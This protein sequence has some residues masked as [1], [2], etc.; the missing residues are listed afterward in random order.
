VAEAA[1]AQG[2][3]FAIAAKRNGAAWRAERA[4]EEWDWRPA[5]GMA[6]EVAECSYVPGWPE[7]TRTIVRRVRLSA[8]EVSADPGAR[9]LR[10]ARRV[11]LRLSPVQRRGPFLSVLASLQAMPSAVP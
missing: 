5:R 1:L 2:C 7:G 6:A 9:V 3:D 10:H 8:G 4:V 11:V